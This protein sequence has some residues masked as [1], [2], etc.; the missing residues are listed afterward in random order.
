MALYYQQQ[1]FGLTLNELGVSFMQNVFPFPKRLV[2]FLNLAT[3]TKSKHQWFVT[4]EL[5]RNWL[6]KQIQLRT[7]KRKEVSR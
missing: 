6:L 3:M 4:L 2:A 5:L 1:E 7:S